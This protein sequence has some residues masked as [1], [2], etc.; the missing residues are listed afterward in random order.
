[1]PIRLTNPIPHEGGSL[2]ISWI[3]GFHVDM[4]NLRLTIWY[5]DGREVDGKQVAVEN[6]EL[7][8]ADMPAVKQMDGTVITPATYEFSKLVSDGP[9]SDADSWH[10]QIKAFLYGI[11]TVRGLIGNGVPY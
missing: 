3:Q 7:T 1:M 2:T 11:L 5:A 9:P 6:R 8:I 4:D 10:M